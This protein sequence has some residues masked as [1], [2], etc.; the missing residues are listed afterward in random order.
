MDN[1]VFTAKL[2]KTVGLAGLLK[3]YIESDFPEQFKKG[4]SFVTNKKLTLTVESF[5]PKN[6]TIK[7]LGIDSIDDAKKLINQQLFSTIEQTR[8]TCNLS[9]KEFF[10]FDIMECKII[11]DSKLLGVVTEVHRYPTSD[12]LEIVTDA[13][14]VEE[15]LPKT[16]LVPYIDQYI[17][18]VEIENK[19]IFTK[20]CLAILENS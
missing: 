5:N 16:F 14:L 7:F 20:D 8:D 19:T 1:K 11:D 18:K 3:V 4:N 9:E 15:G 10:W 12:Y 17:S 6:N 13:A 2:G